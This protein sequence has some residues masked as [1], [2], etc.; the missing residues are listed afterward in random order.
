MLPMI[1]E[2]TLIP[3]T[4]QLLL[5]FRAEKPRS[6]WMPLIL[7][8]LADIACWLTYL[9]ANQPGELTLP[10]LLAIL[11]LLWLAGIALAWMIY[12]VVKAVQKNK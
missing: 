9:R 3:F 12:G 6:K 11:C 10:F 4:I 5:C 7:V 2:S 1:L 8:I